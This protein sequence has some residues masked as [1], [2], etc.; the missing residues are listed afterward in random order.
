MLAFLNP[1]VW[2]ALV[3]VGA[4]GFG[5]GVWRGYSW[6]DRKAEVAALEQGIRQRDA[7]IAEQQRQAAAGR[8][9]AEADGARRR[10]DDSE[11]QARNEQVENYVSTL[12]PERP[13]DLC[14]LSA[15]DVRMLNAIIHS[16]R[17]P[18]PPG[19]PH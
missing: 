1:R 9:I 14:S 8:A 2:L 7:V 4:V 6:A 3:I 12:P 13:D 15:D 10:R 17:A 16:G 19:V 5:A 11:A 18:Q